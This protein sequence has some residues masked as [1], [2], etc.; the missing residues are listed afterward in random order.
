MTQEREVG[1]CPFRR[2]KCIRELCELYAE[3]PVI[4]VSKLA[5][6]AQQATVGGCVFHLMIHILRNPPPPPPPFVPPRAFG[7]S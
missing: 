5:P 2:D 3:M 1:I 7:P 4:K 6:V